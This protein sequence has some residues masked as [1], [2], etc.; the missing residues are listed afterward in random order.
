MCTTPLTYRLFVGVV[1]STSGYGGLIWLL[2]A[3]APPVRLRLTVGAIT[4]TA[5]QK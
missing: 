1:Y 2:S 3:M 4:A 5:Q